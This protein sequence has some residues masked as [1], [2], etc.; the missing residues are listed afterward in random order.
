MTISR[1]IHVAANM[2]IPFHGQV[3]LH[4]MMYHIFFIQESSFFKK[5]LSIFSL[6][7]H[8]QPQSVNSICSLTLVRKVSSGKEPRTQEGL[9]TDNDSYAACFRVG[10][11]QSYWTAELREFSVG[12]RLNARPPGPQY[13][14]PPFNPPVP[15]PAGLEMPLS[16]VSTWRITQ[17]HFLAF[18][19]NLQR[20]STATPC[21]SDVLQGSQGCVSFISY[22]FPGLCFSCYV[23]FGHFFLWLCQVLV[24]ACGI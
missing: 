4:C 13:A 7:F 20:I 11:F 24:A 16:L 21:D 8:R 10:N 17:R 3:I 22:F 12:V 23:E 2:A 14:P 9:F 15:R 5:T 19:G 6:K 1:S 18:T